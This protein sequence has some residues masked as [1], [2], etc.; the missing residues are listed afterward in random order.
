M[1]TDAKILNKILGSLIQQHIITIIHFYQ[2]GFNCRD[3]RMVQRSPLSV[4]HYI[5][6]MNKNQMIIS[7]EAEKTFVKI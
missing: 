4:M 3:A 2:G 6:E 5:N 7:I 1:T